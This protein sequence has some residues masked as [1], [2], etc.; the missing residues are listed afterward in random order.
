MLHRLAQ[1]QHRLDAGIHPRK[2]LTQLIKAATVRA[3]EERIAA[4]EG[5]EQAVAT[6][7]GMAAILAVVMSLCSAGDH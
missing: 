1:A 6:A 2:Q 7:T 4:L 5:A 3:F